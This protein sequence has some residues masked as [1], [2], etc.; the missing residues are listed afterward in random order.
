MVQW[1]VPLTA[2]SLN[3]RDFDILNKGQSGVLDARSPEPGR[4]AGLLT[5]NDI[6]CK[7]F[8]TLDFIRVRNRLINI[9]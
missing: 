9:S 6:F 2:T 3:G 5:G 7:S 1:Q 4:V 8:D